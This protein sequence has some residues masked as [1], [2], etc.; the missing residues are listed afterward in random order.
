MVAR[1]R[2]RLQPGVVGLPGLSGSGKQFHPLELVHTAEVDVLEVVD[3][4]LT[5]VMAD[6]ALNRLF[7]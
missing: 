6:P 5:D 4:C 7:G 3:H 1:R 2:L